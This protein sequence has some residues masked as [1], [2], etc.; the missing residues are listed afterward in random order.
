MAKTYETEEKPKRAFLVSL[1]EAGSG[2]AGKE[3]AGSIARELAGLVNTLGL[4][5]AAQEIVTTRERT[6]KFGMGTGE[7]PGTGRPGRRN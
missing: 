7:S 2:A 5:I 1:M 6:A 3:D 4:E